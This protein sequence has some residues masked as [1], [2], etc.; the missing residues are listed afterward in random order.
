V[1]DG[2]K[3][4]KIS[5]KAVMADLKAEMTDQQLMDKYGLSFEGLQD[6]FSK[7][8]DAKLVSQTYLDNRA[9]KQ[10]WTPPDKRKKTTCP[11][12]GHEEEEKFVKCPRCNQDITEW[13]DTVELT[14]IL[15]F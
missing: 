3:P 11:Y 5:A 2:Q 7:L 6:L 9:R 13:L 14:K 12:C 8:I 10:A 15:T 4:R 1:A